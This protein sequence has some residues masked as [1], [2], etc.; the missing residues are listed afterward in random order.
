MVLEF[1]MKE[2]LGVDVDV[3]QQHDAHVLLVDLEELE[4]LWHHVLPIE[5]H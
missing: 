5:G 2:E 3:G 1:V 4:D